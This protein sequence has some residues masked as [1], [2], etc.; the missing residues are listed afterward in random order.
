MA[1]SDRILYRISGT[2]TNVGAN[3]ETILQLPTPGGPGG[4][5]GF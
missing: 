4:G 1:I 3:E 5:L 2:H